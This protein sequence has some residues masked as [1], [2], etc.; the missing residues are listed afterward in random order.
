[1]HVALQ[2]LRWS[3]WVLVGYAAALIREDEEGRVQNR[4][5]E[6]WI[7][8]MYRR[9]AELSRAAR[10]MQGV[11]TLSSRAFD[12][13]LGESLWSFQ[14]VGAS[15][16]FSLAGFGI[17]GLVTAFAARH[18]PKLASKVQQIPNTSHLWV[19]VA[20][21][22]GFGILPFLAGRVWAL[23]IWTLVAFT[24]LLPLSGFVWFAMNRY[25]FAAVF[26]VLAGIAL[27]LLLSFGFDV[28]YISITR[29]ML[30]MLLRLRQPHEIIGI[31][32]LDV[33]L[34]CALVYGP[35]ELATVLMKPY[36]LGN[37]GAWAF[38][39]LFFNF[40]DFIACSVFFVVM[41]AVLAHRLMWPVLERPIYALQRYGV[42][43]QKKLLWSIWAVLLAG[44]YNIFE[45][46]KYLVEHA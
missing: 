28:L 32:V 9:D 38:A 23:V 37:S 31:V 46:A 6:W 29:L 33:I 45:V 4:L 25:G 44:P 3:L 7:R 22:V 17:A 42:I 16:W 2:V 35:I 15:L 12:S 8:L 26:R 18:I 14:A 13:V 41:L 24:Y 43:R 27:V 10:F 36:L 40:G 30:R 34:A 19:L 11:A 5:E 21:C 1:M 39:A 20:V